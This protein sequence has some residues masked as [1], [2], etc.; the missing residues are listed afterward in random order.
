MRVYTGAA[1]LRTMQ[2]LTQRV[3]SPASLHHV[4]DLAW[5]RFMYAPELADWLIALW[6]DDGRVVAWGWARFP[7]ELKL[8]VDPARW[9]LVDDVLAWFDELA[10]GG[11]REL[12]VLD[13][14]VELREALVRHGY[15][16]QEDV[17]YFAHHARSLL[18]LPKPE[19]PESFTARAVRGEEDLA[20]RVAVHQKA[21]N[22][23]RVTAQSYR[24]VMAAWPYRSELDWVMEA[25]DGEFVANCHIW[26]DEGNRVGLI[27]PV[28]TVPD[29]RHRGL[30][31]AVCLAALHAL[32]EAGA[33]MAVVSPRGDEA[34]PI[35]QALYRSIGFQPYARTHTYVKKDPA[36][37]VTL[38]EN[39]YG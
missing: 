20:N 4:G 13:N 3:W 25:P 5:G 37:I 36:G 18:D 17:P 30:S 26:Y 22:S 12:D 38:T 2:E 15:G 8:Q 28:G 10:D 16:R 34:Y 7:D 35:P 14:Q 24:D 9:E 1:D 39:G 31:R 19:L 33:G 32:H 6:E 27:E 23:T 21:W 29:F 11:V